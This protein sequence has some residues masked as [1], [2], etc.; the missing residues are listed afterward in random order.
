MHKKQ[1]LEVCL[2]SGSYY[3]D[4]HL[5]SVVNWAGTL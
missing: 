1:Q 2:P 4:N 5:S 3:H